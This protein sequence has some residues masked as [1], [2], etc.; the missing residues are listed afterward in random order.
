MNAILGGGSFSSRITERVRSDE[1]LAYSAGTRFNTED[2]DLGMFQA[3][4]QTKT[5]ST[6]KAISLIL[7]EIAKIRTPRTVSRNEF[8]TARESRLFSQIFRFE[9]LPDNVARLMRNELDGL[10]ADQD[11][12]NFEGWNAVTPQAVEAAAQKHLRPDDLTV[13]VVG[14]GKQLAG[15][16]KA[17]GEV[18]LVPL[19]EYPSEPARRPGGA[20]GR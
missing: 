5:E 16:L 17:F 13:F 1:G 2:R 19:K 6:V 7:D 10:P 18:H 11:R 20:P 14:D 12:R 8:E 9:R 3:F 4:V 15:A